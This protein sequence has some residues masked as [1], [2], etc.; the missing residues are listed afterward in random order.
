MSADRD[1]FPQTILYHRV[2]IRFIGFVTNTVARKSLSSVI[3]ELGAPFGVK[4]DQLVQAVIRTCDSSLHRR[5]EHRDPAPVSH[6]VNR[7][8]GTE[9]IQKSTV[10]QRSQITVGGSSDVSRDV[11]FKSG[12]SS[13]IGALCRMSGWVGRNCKINNGVDL[14]VASDGSVRNGPCGMRNE[15]VAHV[16]M[17]GC[18]ILLREPARGRSR[19][20][21]GVCSL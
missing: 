18:A 3:I 2:G 10:V 15:T 20:R 4:Y 14:L 11:L 12:I 13:R 5:I 21:G 7:G 1:V 6:A 8:H 17:W 9:S 19:P 16:R